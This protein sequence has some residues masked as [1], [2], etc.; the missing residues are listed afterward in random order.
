MTQ[1]VPGLRRLEPT[2]LKDK[3]STD[4]A[5]VPTYASIYV[6]RQGAVSQTALTLTP[7]EIA[8]EGIDVTDI[9][10]LRKNDVLGIFRSGA[11]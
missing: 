2:V 5:Q 4:A 3:T 9:G 8:L 6:Y 11:W 10:A 7:N 1:T